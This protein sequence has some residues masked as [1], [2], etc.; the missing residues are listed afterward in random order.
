MNGKFI[1]KILVA[2]LDVTTVPIVL[3]QGR[4]IKAI[5]IRI[6]HFKEW[7]LNNISEESCYFKQVSGVPAR[8]RD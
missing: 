7:E 5:K 4:K 6:D 3:K 2:E 1:P 8:S